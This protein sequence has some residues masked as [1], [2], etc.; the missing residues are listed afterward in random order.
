MAA[1]CACGRTFLF[2]H[3]CAAGTAFSTRARSSAGVPRQLTKGSAAA[4]VKCVREGRLESLPLLGGKAPENGMC[5]PLKLGTEQASLP[6]SIRAT[7]WLRG[8]SRQGGSRALRLAACCELYSLVHGSMQNRHPHAFRTGMHTLCTP[9]PNAAPTDEG[10]EQGRRAEGDGE[11][12]GVAQRA[13][14]RSHRLDC[15]S[16]AGLA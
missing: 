8:A 14:L 12:K 9:A 15:G 16:D 7:H 5:P 6:Y 11:R 4:S 3:S 2:S 10:D 1:L 13:S